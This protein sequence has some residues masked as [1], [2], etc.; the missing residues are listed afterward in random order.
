[1]RLGGEVIASEEE[2]TSIEEWLEEGWRKSHTC[3]YMLLGTE[4]T[5]YKDIVTEEELLI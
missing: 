2:M 4:A 1:M 5:L 3:T